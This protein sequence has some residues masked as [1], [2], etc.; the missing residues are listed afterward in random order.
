MLIA[1]KFRTLLEGDRYNW[2]AP[3]LLFSIVIIFHSWSL[4]R[5]PLP[6][7][8]E[9]WNASRAWAFIQTYRPFGVLDA[10]VFDKFEGYWTFLPRLPTAIQ[11]LGL[12]F[13]DVPS[14]MPLRIISLIFGLILLAAIYAIAHKLGGIILACLSV[15]LVSVSWTFLYSSHLARTD[16]MAAAISFTAVALEYYNRPRRVW[17]DILSGLFLGIALEFH[18]NSIIF[19]PA[20]ASLYYM[21]MGWRML[22]SRYFWAFLIGI[23][24]GVVYYIYIHILP[25]PETYFA[26][27]KLAFTTTHAPPLLTLN[28]KI[29]LLAI[30]DMSWLVLS[31]Y[32]PML[33]LII[34]AVIFLIIKH[35]NVY[36]SLIVFTGVLILAATVLIRSKFNYYAILITPF[37]DV[38]LAIFILK[39]IEKRWRGTFL[40]YLTTVTMWGLLIGTILLNISVMRINFLDNYISTQSNINKLVDPSDIVMASQVFWLGLYENQYYSWEEIIYYQRYAP[41]STLYDALKEFNPDIFIIDGHLRYFIVESR[42]QENVYSQELEIPKPELDAFLDS[43]AVLIGEFDAGYYGLVEIFRINW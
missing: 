12:R 11:S 42:S 6:F 35:F 40:D 43:Y 24:I 7:V 28:P 33:P 9:A 15:F 2:Y 34:W 8:D 21:E 38:L 30:K 4:M 1:N 22:Q 5:Y 3:I 29:M 10:G 23:F 18:P 31:L 20:I 16:I 17:I 13:V 32:R 39:F 36:K 19:F 26:L 37:L 27:N 14:L 41:N 25:Y